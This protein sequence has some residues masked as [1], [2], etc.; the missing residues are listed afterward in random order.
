M[1]RLKVRSKK[2]RKR[3]FPDRGYLGK[4]FLKGRRS[5]RNDMLVIGIHC[6]VWE[7]SPTKLTLKSALLTKRIGTSHRVY[8][9]HFSPLL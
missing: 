7:T 2:K 5:P 1:G 6:S 9:A 4:N 3:A 8:Q